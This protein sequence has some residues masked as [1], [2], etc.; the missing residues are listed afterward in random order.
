MKETRYKT[1]EENIIKLKKYIET[2]TEL[3]NNESEKTKMID[4]SN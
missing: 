2:R 4:E 1:K 3:K